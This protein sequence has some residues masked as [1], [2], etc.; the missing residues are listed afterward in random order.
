MP[1]GQALLVVRCRHK[2][3]HWDKIRPVICPASIQD[4][5][6]RWLRV[7][8][9]LRVR[10]LRAHS[11]YCSDHMTQVARHSHYERSY[12]LVGICLHPTSYSHVATSFRKHAYRAAQTEDWLSWICW[13]GY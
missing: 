1:T 7:R 4:H 13:H 12:K 11:Y 8:H 6:V 9:C 10:D 3:D 5:M 2:N